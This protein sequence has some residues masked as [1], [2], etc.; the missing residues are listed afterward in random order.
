MKNG[1][2]AFIGGDKR[3]FCCAEALSERGL[4]CALYGFDRISDRASSTRTP[5]IRDCLLNA[6]ALVLPVPLTRDGINVNCDGIGITLAEVLS[7]VE[8][9]TPI[10]A[11]AVS[12]KAAAVARQY[13]RTIIDF[14][15]D[16]PLCEKN[17][18][19]TA[20]GAVSLAM[21]SID[22]AVF[23]KSVLVTGYG[24][25]ASY[26]ARLLRSLGAEVTVF[27]RRDISRTKAELDGHR[28]I[29]QMGLCEAIAKAD[30]I[31][32]T[33]PAR[34]FGEAEASRFRSRQVY[35]ELASSPY[36][37]DKALA[38]KNN[39]EIT[40]GSSLPSRYCPEAAGGYIAD[41]LA[42]QFEGM[43]II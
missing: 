43:G 42:K 11:G 15:L 22:G 40:D 30:I 25:I 39:L 19:L 3:M 2:I 20:E 35:I 29:G 26:T 9:E 32:N 37:I 10:F 17:A 1:K 27:A 31:F 4:E 5:S 23:G 36:G 8:A 38:A 34:I 41:Y 14:L 33:V 12:E 6:Q 24:R 16:E 28:A 7:A 18:Y 21:R 13:D